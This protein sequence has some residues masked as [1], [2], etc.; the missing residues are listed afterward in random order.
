MRTSWSKK[1]P[2]FLTK[3]PRYFHFLKAFAKKDPLPTKQRTLDSIS[4]VRY[5][6]EGKHQAIYFENLSEREYARQIGLSQKGV[7]KR[8]HKILK[9][10]RKMMKK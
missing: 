10:L 2:V 1:L 4:R 3:F 7:N 5:Y 9:E 6:F 8:K